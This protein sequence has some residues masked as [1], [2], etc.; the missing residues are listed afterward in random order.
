MTA[1][2]CLK[3]KI[4]CIYDDNSVEK[5]AEAAARAL[6]AA[7]AVA[8]VAESCTGGLISKL[9]TDVP[10]ASSVFTGSIVSYSNEIKKRLL[11]VQPDILIR[12]GAVSEP[13]ALEMARGARR[14]CGADVAI[15]TTGIAG[16]GGGTPDKPVGTV[17][18]AISCDVW[19][20]AFVLNLPPHESRTTIRRT[21]AAFA[22]DLLAEAARR[23][24]QGKSLNK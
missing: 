1:C 16:P 11:G 3:M 9:I 18:V 22:L 17:W 14:A 20:E 19:E 2:Y 21:T 7:G 10:G 15:S 8:A 23:I 4:D 6:K 12:H 13:T 24:Q 5:T